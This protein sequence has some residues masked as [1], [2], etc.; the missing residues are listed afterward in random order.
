MGALSLGR[1]KG[2]IDM[3]KALAT[4]SSPRRTTKRTRRVFSQLT[5]PGEAS[6]KGTL[7]V[8]TTDEEAERR[9]TLA[10]MAAAY[11]AEIRFHQKYEG[12]SPDESRFETDALLK[13]Y[14]ETNAECPPEDVTWGRIDAAAQEDIEA[15]LSLWLRVRHASIDHIESG[16]YA[17]SAINAT[18]PFQMAHFA[19]IR[20]KFSDDW[21]PRGGIEAAMIDMLAQSF[22]LYMT[23]ISIADQRARNMHD[24]QRKALSR[25]EESSWKSPYQSQA[26]AT[27]QARQTADSYN[28]MFLRTLRQMRDLRRYP[29]TIQNN[30]GQVNVGAQQVNVSESTA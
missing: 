25:Y 27:E 26:D 13:Y 9:A 19:A 17:A 24:D 12:R 16:Q 7:T 23:W 30:G 28:R 21:Q 14:R 2:K 29:V 15:G 5:I 3:S 18:T 1:T 22:C 10:R 6:A 20:D 4:T 11:A 8:T